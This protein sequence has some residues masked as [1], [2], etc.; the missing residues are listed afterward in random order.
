M[1]ICHEESEISEK[2]KGCCRRERGENTQEL[3]E[4]VIT[5]YNV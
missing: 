4:N 1:W 2:I 5:V 3:G